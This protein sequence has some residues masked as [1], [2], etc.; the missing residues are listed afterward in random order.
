MKRILIFSVVLLTILITQVRA[1][2]QDNFEKLSAYKV[3]FFTQKL[4]LS[5]AEAE[6]FWPLYNDFSARRS[7]IQTDRASLIRY[8]SQNEANMRDQELTETANKLAQ[9]F[10]DEAN[11]IVYFNNEI[12]KALPPAKVIR[13]YQAESQYKLQLLKELNERRQVQGGGQRNQIRR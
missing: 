11:L 8:A 5:P 3:A 7:K 13:L 12:Q 9:T 6:K 10:V 1:Q 2:D 4:N